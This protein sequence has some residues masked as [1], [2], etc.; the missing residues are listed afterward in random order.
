MGQRMTV[1]DRVGQAIA[2]GAVEAALRRAAES[3]RRV[4]VRAGL[5]L[6]VWRDGHL[7]WIEPDELEQYDADSFARPKQGPATPDS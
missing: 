3:A 2:N 7:L 4:Y 6:P 1:S 5:S